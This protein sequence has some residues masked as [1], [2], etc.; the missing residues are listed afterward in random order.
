MS[1]TLLFIESTQS[2]LTYYDGDGVLSSQDIVVGVA[3]ALVLAACFSWLNGNSSS[4]QFIT[5]MSQTTTNDNNKFD[6]YN[7]TSTDD[8]NNNQP[9]DD[10]MPKTKNN[11]AYDWEEISRP[12]NYILFSTRIKNKINS[13]RKL[14][15]FDNNN[16]NMNNRKKS[17]ST[18]QIIG[19]LF[20]FVPLFSFELF[21]TISRQFICGTTTTTYNDILHPT[22]WFSSTSVSASIWAQQLCSPVQ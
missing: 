10:A 17:K 20:I 11:I 18:N 15:T 12:D 9:K 7:N 8:S 1:S 14:L 19:L 13:S 22:S 3:I 4:S 6:I 5:S 2:L 16:N 21:F